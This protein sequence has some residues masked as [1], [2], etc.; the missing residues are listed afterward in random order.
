MLIINP[1]STAEYIIC[2]NCTTIFITKRDNLVFNASCS[3]CKSN[4][5]LQTF[6]ISKIPFIP[7]YK[8]QIL[9]IPWDFE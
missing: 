3:H 9:S 6:D 5:N 1:L 7:H 2:Y 4:Q 8:L